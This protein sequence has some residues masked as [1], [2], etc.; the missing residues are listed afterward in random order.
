M[1]KNNMPNWTELNLSELVEKSLALNVVPI[2]NFL[3]KEKVEVT[4]NKPYV[5]PL[6]ITPIMVLQKEIDYDLR[7]IEKLDKK[8]GIS[9]STP[10]EKINLL[11][12][13]LKKRIA[14]FR[15]AIKK[16]KSQP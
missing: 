9:P 2:F 1:S 6:E 4:T 11:K 15:K 3:S 7:F 14:M 5:H 16:L 8:E 13:K 12:K 10:E